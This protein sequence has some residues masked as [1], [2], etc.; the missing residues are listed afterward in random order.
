[1]HEPRR[2]YF[3]DR[4]TVLFL[5]AMLLLM[6][7]PLWATDAAEIGGCDGT[8]GTTIPATP[9]TYLGLLGTLG[10]GDT[11][12]L[13]AGTYTGGLPLDGITG[14]P[15]DCVIIEGPSGWP[16]T[17]RLVATQSN[18]TVNIIDSRYLVLRNLEIDGTG[19]TVSADGVKLSGDASFG[20]HIT[21]ENLFI[22]D[23]DLFQGTVG[24]STKAPAWNWVIR[25]NVIENCGTGL[26]LGNS[27]GEEEF[28]NSLIE[29]NLIR[30]TI[31]Y[32]AQIKHQNGRAT[33]LGI[34]AD[35]QTIIRHNVFSKID[36]SSGGA[37]AR[38]NL[39][40]GHWPLSG[41]GSNDDYLIY[42]NFFYQ[43]ATAIE[44]LFQ[45]EGNI[46]FYGNLL[47]NDFGDAVRFKAHNDQPRR[48]RAFQNT[49]VATGVG[50]LVSSPHP[51]FSQELTGNAAFAGTPLS[52]GTQSDNSSDT[53]ANAV[54][55]LTSPFLA[56]GAGLDLYPILASP[57]AQSV[58]TT[59]LNTWE[60]WDLD[61][62]GEPRS[63]DFRGA[64]AG[65]GT[66][67]GWTLVLDRKPPVSS[68][69]I[70]QDG[71]ESGSLSMWSSSSP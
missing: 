55:Y 50:L 58:D 70:F 67:P 33:G 53:R 66:N 65:A 57:L 38:P 51:S 42:G 69:R 68:S 36:N 24:I 17:A 27:N 32:N 16:P 7:S 22:H 3:G 21:L 23:H 10:P 20:D 35:G 12:Q 25:N 52:G 29:Y 41:P 44:P 9:A 28:V 31:G 13:A 26:Y 64:Y 61:F 56:P 40:V 4:S 30:D 43:N 2:A 6:V 18:N 48:I 62:N 1:M 54:S 59:G 34:P 49:V 60:D 19:D 45:G 71:F 46:I 8:Q 11:L 15:Q 37:D 47:I 14:Q 63:V 5:A 39:L